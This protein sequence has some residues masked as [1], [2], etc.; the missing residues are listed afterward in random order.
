MIIRQWK[1]IVDDIKEFEHK[2]SEHHYVED[3]IPPLYRQLASFLQ[4]HEPL[5]RKWMMDYLEAN[6]KEVLR[7]WWTTYLIRW[8][9]DQICAWSP[10]NLHPRVMEDWDR[11]VG[12]VPFSTIHR[13]VMKLYA[14][15][16]VSYCD[17]PSILA[18]H[19]DKPCDDPMFCF[20]CDETHSKW[21]S[22]LE[23][24]LSVIHD[25]MLY[26]YKEPVGIENWT[27]PHLYVNHLELREYKLFLTEE[28]VSYYQR[29]ATSRQFI[30]TL[31]LKTIHHDSVWVLSTWDPCDYT[32]FTMLWDKLDSM[33][34][35]IKIDMIC[36]ERI[37]QMRKKLVYF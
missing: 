3:R 27:P 29:C 10:M 4:T 36:V 15:R 11:Y 7:R 17:V 13:E 32:L 2:N 16:D 9:K 23:E 28:Y 5:L 25:T 21:T 34:F 8:S 20:L 19:Q 1:K 31:L 14:N 18:I 12:T 24:R 37:E 33:L 26:S 6:R 30:E 22:E 35:A